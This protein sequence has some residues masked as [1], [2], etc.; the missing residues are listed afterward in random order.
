MCWFVWIRFVFLAH[1]YFCLFLV[2]IKKTKV[3]N[4]CIF[5]IILHFTVQCFDN[6]VFNC[7]S[8]LLNWISF[9]VLAIDTVR[10]I[11]RLLS[12]PLSN[13]R[14]FHAM[15][16]EIGMKSILHCILASTPPKKRFVLAVQ[17]EWEYLWCWSM[18]VLTKFGY[19]F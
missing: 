10:F 18:Y 13:T 4:E 7:L 11:E 1:I 2:E 19:S 6:W 8:E 16:R 15:Q 12:L 3:K 14:S 17:D 5:F 9:P